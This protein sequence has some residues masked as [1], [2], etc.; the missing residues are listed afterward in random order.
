[1]MANMPVTADTHHHR[2]T[3]W[4]LFK[5]SEVM[6]R[7]TQSSETLCKDLRT[8]ATVGGAVRAAQR[9]PRVW[10][11]YFSQPVLPASLALIMLYFN[12]VLS[13]GGLMTAFLSS[14]GL[15]Q[16]AAPFR[17][18]Q[19]PL[20]PIRDFPEHLFRLACDCLAFLPGNMSAW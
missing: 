4:C 5:N 16:V 2:A 14:L 10:R 6:T 17:Y 13:P 18:D 7:H 20:C 15:P 9:L 3:S 12:A 1:M 11:A 19:I 8:C